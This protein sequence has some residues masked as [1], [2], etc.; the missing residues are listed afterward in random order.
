MEPR[1]QWDEHFFQYGFLAILLATLVVNH[2][3]EPIKSEGSS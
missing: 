1:G 3:K 2:Q